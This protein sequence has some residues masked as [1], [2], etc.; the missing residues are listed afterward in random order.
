MATFFF[1]I[2]LFI[3]LI[4]YWQ[5]ILFILFFL[6]VIICIVLIIKAISESHERYLNIQKRLWLL[7]REK[8]I[9]DLK[10]EK[11]KKQFE[12]IKLE[13]L[14]KY[15]SRLK[16]I[17]LITINF[18][19]NLVKSF[20]KIHQANLEQEKERQLK[21]EMLQKINEKKE[22]EKKLKLK[23]EQ[24]L[25]E[26]KAYYTL[27]M[28]IYKKCN[29]LNNFDDETFRVVAYTFGV[30]D[31]SVAKKMYYDVLKQETEK[32]KKKKENELR[33][34]RE[35]QFNEEQK[36]I[37]DNVKISKKKMKKRYNNEKLEDAL[38][39]EISIDKINEYL[40]VDFVKYM[41]TNTDRFNVSLECKL[42]KEIRIV[43]MPGVLDGSFNII[44][45]DSN[46]NVV[47]SGYFNGFTNNTNIGFKTKKYSILCE[48]SKNYKID[49][50]MKYKIEILPMY[51]WILE[52]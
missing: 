19:K 13:F 7:C 43:N 26:R 24:E 45:K 36:I 3:F 37:N 8:G 46:S 42:K 39:D 28:K 31:V 11:D 38:I 51:F 30:S 1:L 32:M 4:V 16:Y 9:T 2:F 33:R 47:A 29:S 35:K 17:Y 27:A 50:E 48:V 10:S 34:K 6:S 41:I 23:Q 25:K 21:A 49:K 12:K 44:V 18:K 52:L 14:P 20:E 40:N 15:H 22:L 5:E